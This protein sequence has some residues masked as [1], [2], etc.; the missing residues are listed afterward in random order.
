MRRSPI[1]CGPARGEGGASGGDILGH[2]KIGAF[3]AVN[4]AGA[5]VLAGGGL[6]VLSEAPLRARAWSEFEA[7]TGGGVGGTDWIAPLADYPAP[8]GFAWPE[9][10][11]T[12]RGRHWHL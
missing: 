8:L 4:R 5:R 10:V 11:E 7:R 3:C 12:V 1:S 2:K 9:Y 6:R